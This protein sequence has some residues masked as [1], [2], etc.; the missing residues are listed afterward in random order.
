MEFKRLLLYELE[1][2]IHKKKTI[3]KKSNEYMAYLVARGHSLKKVKQAFENVGKMTRTE[4]RV[5]K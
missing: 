5:K 3:W 2:F 4:K 1:E